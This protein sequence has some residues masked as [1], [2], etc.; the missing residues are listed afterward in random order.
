MCVYDRMFVKYVVFIVYGRNGIQLSSGCEYDDYGI[1]GHGV[2]WLTGFSRFLQSAAACLLNNMS[3]L[4][5]L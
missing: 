2:F 4:R 5:K 3:D 1:F